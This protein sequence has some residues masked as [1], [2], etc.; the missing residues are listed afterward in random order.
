MYIFP[1]RK[2]LKKLRKKNPA[3]RLFVDEVMKKM[4][5]T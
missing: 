5:D 2:N 3:S 1:N 4:Y